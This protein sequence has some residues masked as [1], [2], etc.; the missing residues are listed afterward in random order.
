MDR[1]LRL[2]I[3]FIISLLATLWSLYMGYFWDPLINI[4][5]WDLFNSENFLK[6][7]ILCRYTRIAIYPIVLLSWMWLILND[8]QIRRYIS[9]FLGIGLIISLYQNIMII[10][11]NFTNWFCDINNPCTIGYLNY[12]W[13]ITIPLLAFIALII[14]SA[15]TIWWARKQSHGTNS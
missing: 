15:M 1:P 5:S 14:M 2:W 9:P 7:C 13:F 8:Q 6:I 12:F 11:P 10:A 3:T 4:L